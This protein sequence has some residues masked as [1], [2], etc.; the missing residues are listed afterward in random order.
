MKKAGRKN[1]HRMCVLLLIILLAAFLASAGEARTAA[2]TAACGSFFA[3]SSLLRHCCRLEIENSSRYGTGSENQDP[4]A[5]RSQA[6]EKMK[7]VLS[8]D[9]FRWDPD[10]DTSLLPAYA[11]PVN[12][13]KAP[14]T[15]GNITEDSTSIYLLL[16]CFLI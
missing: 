12:V 1:K 11:L 15:V 14:A 5:C 7:T 13:Q 3:C 6:D 4:C 10:K 9:S 16:V 8:T 2:R